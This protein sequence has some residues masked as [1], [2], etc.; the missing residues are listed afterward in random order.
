MLAEHDELRNT[1]A[2]IQ[3]AV[4]EY[5]AGSDNLETSAVIQNHGNHFI[6]VLRDHINKEDNILFPLADRV[7]PIE[8]HDAILAGFE[9]VEHEDTGEGVHE[10]YLALAQE[11]ARE[12][13]RPFEQTPVLG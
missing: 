2:E 7:I 12:A 1:N 11:L 8:E 6:T 4:H 9:T 3:R 5:L 13:D 10:K